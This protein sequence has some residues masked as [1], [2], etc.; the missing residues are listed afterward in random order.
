MNVKEN[1]KTDVKK[2]NLKVPK[3][4]IHKTCPT[5][6]VTVCNLFLGPSEYKPYKTSYRWANV[7]CKECLKDKP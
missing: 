2:G 5:W 4:M 3:Y 7:T 6:A 1:V